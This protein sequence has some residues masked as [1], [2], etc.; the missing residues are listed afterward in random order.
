M[1]DFPATIEVDG[2]PYTIQAPVPSESGE[3]YQVLDAAGESLGAIEIAEGAVQRGGSSDP[4]LRRVA[5]RA[6]ETGIVK[7]GA[8]S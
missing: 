2:Q 4:T 6:I 5:Q 3:S 7:V 1:S 8:R